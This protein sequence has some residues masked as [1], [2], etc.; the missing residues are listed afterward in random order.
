M[1][2]IKSFFLKGLSDSEL[3]E[4]YRTSHD[5]VYFGE[6]FKRYSYVVLATCKKYL[7][8]RDAAKDAA[9]QIFGKLLE[10]GVDAKI[11]NFSSWLHVVAKNHCLMQLRKEKNL[12]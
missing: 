5:P 9:M 2:R 8:G 11:Y 6:L 4:K 10:E 12:Q 1:F 3:L 7:Y